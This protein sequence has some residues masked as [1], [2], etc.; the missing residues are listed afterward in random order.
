MSF[1]K[2]EKERRKEA[3]LLQEKYTAIGRRQP[4]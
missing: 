4:T 2:I 1:Q 3:L